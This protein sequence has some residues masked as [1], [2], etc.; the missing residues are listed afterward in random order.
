MF[1]FNHPSLNCNYRPQRNCGKVMFSQ[2]SVILFTGVSA[3]PPS[4][5]DDYCSGR[6]ASYWNAFLFKMFFQGNA[7]ALRNYFKMQDIGIVRA[8]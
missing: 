1:I 2:A 3:R 5:A 7:C 8:F 6:Y 4:R